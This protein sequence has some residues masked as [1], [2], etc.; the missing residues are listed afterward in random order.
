[1]SALHVSAERNIDAPV[2]TVLAVLR[3]FDGHHRKILPAAFSNLVVEEGGHGA[4]TVISFDISLGGRTESARARIEEP[5]PGVIEEHLIGREMVT[6]FTVRPERGGANTRIETRWQPARGLTG[7]I[8]RV[9][10]PRM[11]RQIYSDELSNL[12]HVAGSLRGNTEP[13]TVAQ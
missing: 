5:E 8:E 10:A 12:N 3:D 6:T 9:F 13:G 4:G 7:L 1:M 2:S 11:L